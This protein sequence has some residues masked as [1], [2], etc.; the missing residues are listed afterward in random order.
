[1]GISTGVL[2]LVLFFVVPTP[3]VVQRAARAVSCGL[4]RRVVIG[5]IVHC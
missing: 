4:L 5:P 2:G 1:M 3:N